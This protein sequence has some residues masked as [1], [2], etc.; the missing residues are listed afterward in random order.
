MATAAVEVESAGVEPLV[1]CEDAVMTRQAIL[2]KIPRAAI[3]QPLPLD[4][5]GDRIEFM[6]QL[7]A[8]R[9]E[10]LGRFAGMLVSASG[11]QE[12]NVLIGS[13]SSGVGKTHLAYAWGASHGF[14]ILSRTITSNFRASIAPPFAWLLNQLLLLKSAQA[15]DSLAV[16]AAAS[17]FVRLALLAFVHFSV[18]ALRALQG[19]HPTASLAARRRLLLR[20]HRNGNAD[21]LV[22]AIPDSLFSRMRILKC[23]V[24]HDFQS[25][26]SLFVSQRASELL[27]DDSA[28]VAGASQGPATRSLYYALVLELSSLQ[29]AHGWCMYVTGTALSMRRVA[30]SSNASV[31][32][33]CHPVDF[34]PAH[35]LS[36][37]DMISIL[38]S[39]WVLDDVLSDETILQRLSGFIGRPQLFVAG[40]FK[41]LLMWIRMNSHLPRAPELAAALDVSF[42]DLVRS[43]KDLFIGK[44]ESNYPVARDGKGAQALIPLLFKA[45]V[46]DNSVIM[47]GGADQLAASICTGLL[48]VSSISAL[49]PVN[50]RDEPVIFEGI[51]A[52]VLDPAHEGRVLDV[53]VGTSQPIPVYV[54]GGTLEI[55]V[56]WHVALTC[57]RFTDPSLAKVLTT[58]GVTPSDIPP[59]LSSWVVRATRVHDDKQGH[60][61]VAHPTP[62]QSY[63][64][65]P[66]GGID[67]SRVIF[68]IPTA[69]GVDIAFLVSRVAPAHADGAES[70]KIFGGRQFKLVVLQCRNVVDS[71]VADTL[72]TLHPGTQFLNNLAR[73]RLLKLTAEHPTRA[74]QAGWDK[75][76]ALAVDRGKSFLVRNWVRIAVVARALDPK[77]AAFSLAAAT[78]DVTDGHV[79]GWN[80][81]QCDLA[82]NSPVVWVSLA[83]PFAPCA[84][85]FPDSV[86]RSLVGIAADADCSTASAYGG[87]P[88]TTGGS[89][90]PRQSQMTLLHHDLWV[91][92]PVSDAADFVAQLLTAG[93]KRKRGDGGDSGGAADF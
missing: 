87:A 93:S 90:A 51:R 18:L 38:S 19:S 59:T 21:A 71:T 26:S 53:L 50:M 4:T 46:M 20:L 9:G 79:R 56:S 28:A 54:K 63:F 30:D 27:A 70:G 11:A 66:D 12:G 77:I 32:A 33:R 73:C 72:L 39:Y 3:R 49:G 60:E 85:V 16:S 65:K 13:A 25:V 80:E 64:V 75:W 1:S 68:N 2:L 48:A 41:P 52:A 35:R 89:A 76:S 14:S 22:T 17:L 88:Q 55:A 42:H 40:V 6:P 82:A 5:T 29:T 62:F 10:D 36:V 43:Q 34:A 91:P 31:M 24:D 86:R 37:P 69:M 15:T 78:A 84:G 92:V 67:D 23:S 8:S 45:A 57:N 61:T 74:T 83:K 7:L 47:L 81:S 44:V 58:L